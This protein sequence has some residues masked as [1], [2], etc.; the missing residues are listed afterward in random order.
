MT[1]EYR[2]VVGITIRV[3]NSMRPPRR[4]TTRFI[5]GL[6]GVGDQPDWQI[7]VRSHVGRKIQDFCYI[8]L[9]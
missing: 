6:A 8:T 9:L 5:T 2:K 4:T 7:E 1:D 3:K